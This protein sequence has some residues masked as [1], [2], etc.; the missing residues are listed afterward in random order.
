MCIF[1]ADNGSGM[2]PDQCSRIF[3]PFYSTKPEGMGTGLGL[4]VSYGLIRRYGGDITVK[5]RPGHGTVFMIWLLKEPH[6][7]E[8]AETI[9]EQ[10][11]AAETNQTDGTGS[12]PDRVRDDRSKQ[13]AG[14]M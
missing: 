8:D 5:S 4:S 13:S 6:L 10:L 3:N 12:D 2:T 14:L 1:V 9:A 7:T 11:H